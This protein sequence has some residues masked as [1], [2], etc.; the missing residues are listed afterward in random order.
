MTNIWMADQMQSALDHA[1]SVWPHKEIAIEDPQI[2]YA[3]RTAINR[4]QLWPTDRGFPDVRIIY[5]ATDGLG[6]YRE[7]VDG[8]EWLRNQ[9]MHRAFTGWCG[10]CEQTQQTHR[11]L[12]VP[13]GMSIVAVELCAGCTTDMAINFSPP[14]WM[15]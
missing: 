11:L 9:H 15:D 2:D 13:A 6:Y 1:E 12:Y 14:K 10:R 5:P 4:V 8:P 7:Q 3:V